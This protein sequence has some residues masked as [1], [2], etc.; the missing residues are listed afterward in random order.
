MSAALVVLPE[1]DW[2][3]GIPLGSVFANSAVTRC[4][5]L[6]VNESD[7]MM[8]ILAMS[9]MFETLAAYASMVVAPSSKVVA[10]GRKAQKW[11][12]TAGKHN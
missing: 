4:M 7:G 10:H 12:H 6:L 8:I 1:K 11:W 3:F 2:P 9:V 5:L